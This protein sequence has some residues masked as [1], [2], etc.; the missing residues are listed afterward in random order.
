MLAHRFKEDFK[1][2]QA[3]SWIISLHFRGPTRFFKVFQGLRAESSG[4]DGQLHC[5]EI[6]SGSLLWSCRVS[7]SDRDLEIKGAPV[8][9]DDVVI[10]GTHGGSVVGVDAGRGEPLWRLRLPG[11]VFASPALDGRAMPP[12]SLAL[13]LSPRGL[14]SRRRGS[15]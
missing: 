6:E 9:V 14:W 11:A 12:G 15:R 4:Y 10:V 1:P 7:P 3:A 13:A 5:V 8:V 2:S